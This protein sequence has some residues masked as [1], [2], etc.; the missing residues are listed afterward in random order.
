M[1]WLGRKEVREW[2]REL[3]KLVWGN[4]REHGVIAGQ[5]SVIANARG[6]RARGGGVWVGWLVG[7]NQS[8]YM[9]TRRKWPLTVSAQSVG[10]REGGKDRILAMI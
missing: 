1:G 2:Y 9:V 10:H 4:E 5:E 3:V 8:L 7:G 6:K